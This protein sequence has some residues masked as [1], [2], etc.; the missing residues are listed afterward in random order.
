MSSKAILLGR[1]GQWKCEAGHLYSSSVEVKNDGVLIPPP[2]TSPSCVAQLV[3]Y[4]KT[5]HFFAF[6]ASLNPVS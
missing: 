1:R 6:N 3:M 5:L 4:R 2:H